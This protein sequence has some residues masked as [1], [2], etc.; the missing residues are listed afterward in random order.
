M[1]SAQGFLACS[2]PCNVTGGIWIVDEFR[3][4][5]Y[6]CAF[7]GEFELNCLLLRELFGFLTEQPASCT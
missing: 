1:M 7:V 2:V 6:A 3:W 5:S 4:M